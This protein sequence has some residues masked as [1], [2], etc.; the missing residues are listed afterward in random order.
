MADGDGITPARIAM[1]FQSLI[2]EMASV[3]APESP[4]AER[5]V[6][7]PSAATSSA[8]SAIKTKKVGRNDPCSCGSKKKFKVCCGKN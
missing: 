3:L 7:T 6:H 5:Q 8:G 4:N 2:P 1:K